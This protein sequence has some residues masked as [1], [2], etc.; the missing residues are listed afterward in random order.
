MK[1][2]SP[3][4]REPGRWPVALLWMAA[5]LLAGLLLSVMVGSVGLDPREVV[6]AL[7]GIQGA[8]GDP[9]LTIVRQIRLPRAILA[10]MVG[11]CLALA[12]LGLSLIHI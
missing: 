9:T 7:L 10:G 11:A 2:R 4:L 12:G 3:S 1:A 5:I 8:P 6:R